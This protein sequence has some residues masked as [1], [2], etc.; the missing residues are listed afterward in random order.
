MTKML[1][2]ALLAIGLFIGILILLE[3]GRR[4]GGRRLAIDPEGRVFNLALFTHFL[5]PQSWDDRMP[6]DVA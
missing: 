5:V 1:V 4:I 2:A 6:H 3:V